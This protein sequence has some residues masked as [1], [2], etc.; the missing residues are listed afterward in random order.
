MICRSSAIL[1]ELHSYADNNLAEELQARPST[2][3]CSAFGL[4]LI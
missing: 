1:E 3:V 2:L 4:G